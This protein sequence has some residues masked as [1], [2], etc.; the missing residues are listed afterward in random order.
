MNQR[1]LGAT[2][3][4]FPVYKW[5]LL[6][7]IVAGMLVRAGLIAKDFGSIDDP[8]NYLTLAKSLWNGEGFAINGRPTAYR[9][10]LFPILLVAVVAAMPGHLA[11][12]IA[13]VQVG[14]G[15][16][17]ILAT[18][19]TARRWTF[20]TRAALLAAAIVAFDPVLVSQ[21]RPVMTETLAAFLAAVTLLGLTKP[22]PA[23]A[24]LGGLGFGLSALCRPSV[25]PAIGL[26]A[27]AALFLRHGARLER[28][29]FATLMVAASLLIVA[30]WAIRNA[31]V[32][33]EPIIT[34][35]HGGYTLYL[36]NNPVYYQEVL[37]GP[38]GTVWTGPNQWLWWDAVNRD[39]RGMPEPEADRFARRAALKVIADQPADFARASAA[40]LGRFWGL[41]PAGSVYPRWLRIASTIW[42]LPLWI[43]LA[44]GACRRESWRWPM[45]VAPAFILGL[46]FVHAFF[47]TDLRMRA[48]I[49]PALA[50]VAPLAIRRFPIPQA[51]LEPIRVRLE[52]G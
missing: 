25:W 46:S 50:L 43:A 1:D 2:S 49:V 18:A 15:V 47:W 28:L 26:S 4:T 42:T 9:P 48:S 22:G 24:A 35:T 27:L 38:S 45:A 37:N 52:R 44:I 5:W 10:P 23:G 13:L 40:R 20:S 34:T 14:L 29:R 12:G 39:T 19:E 7:L 3:R 41:A 21:A 51:G 11:L 32:L 31:I 16:L 17:T 6:A 30:P 36:A 8:D 33:G